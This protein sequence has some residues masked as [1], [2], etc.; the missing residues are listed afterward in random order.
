MS[1]L[2]AC[3]WAARSAAALRDVFGVA[4]GADRERHQIMDV[5]HH[6]TMQ[7]GGGGR[8]LL[9]CNFEILGQQSRAPREPR[10]I[11]RRK[12]ILPWGQAR[13]EDGSGN[14]QHHELPR[15]AVRAVQWLGQ[16]DE[17]RITVA[18][19]D[20][21]SDLADEMRAPLVQQQADVFG[22]VTVRARAPVACALHPA[23]QGQYAGQPPQRQV[24]LDRVVAH[25]MGFVADA[26]GLEELLKPKG[27]LTFAHVLDR[28]AARPDQRRPRGGQ[29]SGA[30]GRV[31]ARTAH[32][33]TSDCARTSDGA[34]P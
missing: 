31:P 24:D 34:R 1:C 25:V 13:S 4:R 10:G 28:Q 11:G 16:G 29:R 30:T 23:R 22:G 32:Q 15:W 33:R 7:T 6:R 18:E 2:I 5:R 17:C 19:H 20:L 21:A 12:L 27:T 8:A 9:P 14:A 26:Q 3:N